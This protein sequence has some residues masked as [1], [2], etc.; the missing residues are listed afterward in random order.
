MSHIFT[1]TD[2]DAVSLLGVSKLIWA[3]KK[4][5]NTIRNYKPY[6]IKLF[7]TVNDDLDFAYKP[8]KNLSVAET[9]NS[10]K[11]WMNLIWL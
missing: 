7:Y 6:I 11:R 9:T 10:G 4:L 3:I 1:Y 2:S 8:N 5:I